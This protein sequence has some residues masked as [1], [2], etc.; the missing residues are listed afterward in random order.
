M[1][2]GESGSRRHP[3][4][5]AATARFHLKFSGVIQA[6]SLKCPAVY[7]KEM[8]MMRKL[9]T[10]TTFVLAMGCSQ[11]Q[12]DLP[13]EI[14]PVATFE[15]PWSMAF[16]PDGRMLVAEKK[17]RLAV[18]AEDGQLQ[19]AVEGLPDVDYAGA[20]RFWRRR[21]ASGFR[22]QW[23]ALYKLRRGRCRRHSRRSRRSR[24]AHDDGT[25]REIV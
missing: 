18:V 17:G 13:F 3:R 25:W 1:S 4:L 7:F 21:S 11:A 14:T 9:L 24:R 12:S 5:I 10:I 19:G 15:E 6:T 2:S 20:G 22:D 8:R 16:L 23:I